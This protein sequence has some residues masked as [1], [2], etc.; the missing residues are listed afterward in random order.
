MGC[1]QSRRR[2]RFHSWPTPQN[3]SPIYSLSLARTLP[4]SIKP[5][6]LWFSEIRDVFPRHSTI[7]SRGKRCV[8]GMKEGVYREIRN[9]LFFYSPFPSPFS[10]PVLFLHRVL[11]HILFLSISITGNPL[12]SNF[13][14]CIRQ[15]LIWIRKKKL[16]MSILSKS[17]V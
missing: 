8:R 5:H 9:V 11:I 14:R 16:L 2:N 4:S 13:G 17:I 3:A 6:H 7:V 15:N 1:T 10:L 12:I